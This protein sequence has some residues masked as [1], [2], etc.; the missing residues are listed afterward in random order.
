MSYVRTPCGLVIM[1]HDEV[2]SYV[3][4]LARMSV[5]LGNHPFGAIVMRG[6]EILAVGENRVVVASDPTA[7]AEIEAIRQACREVGRVSLNDCALYASCQPCKM[8]VEVIIRCQIRTVHYL[9]SRA[10]AERYGFHDT[11]P[12]RMTQGACCAGFVSDT[13]APFIAWREG[14]RP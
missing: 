2:A 10:T 14:C 4:M 3:L 1:Y 12:I 7:H 6:S 5:T 13:E 8:C 9:A 11:S